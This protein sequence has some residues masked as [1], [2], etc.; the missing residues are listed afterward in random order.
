MA[1]RW[2]VRK[3]GTAWVAFHPTLGAWAYMSGWRSAFDIAYGTATWKEKQR[4]R[5]AA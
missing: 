1:D 3:Q 5:H 2:W 4:G